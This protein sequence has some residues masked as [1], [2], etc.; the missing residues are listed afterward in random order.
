MK[1]EYGFV[2]FLH[3]TEN[4]LMTTPVI[5]AYTKAQERNAFLEDTIGPIRPETESLE[6]LRILAITAPLVALVLVPIQLVLLYLYN[7][8][9]HPWCNF[10]QQFNGEDINSPDFGNVISKL[11]IS[12]QD[13]EGIDQDCKNDVEACQSICSRDSPFNLHPVFSIFE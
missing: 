13:E 8:F 12:I 10:F 3:A 2:I 7:C 9:G 11:D 5:Y 1:L 6:R 4:L